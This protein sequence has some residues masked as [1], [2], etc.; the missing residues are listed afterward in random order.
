[1]NEEVFRDQMILALMPVFVEGYL[2]E[3]QAGHAGTPQWKEGLAAQAVH[4]AMIAV[5]VRKKLI[6]RPVV[7]GESI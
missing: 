3:A 2:K 4:T 6:N 7:L 1:M 5:E